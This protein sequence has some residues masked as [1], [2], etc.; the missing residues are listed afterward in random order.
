MIF[1]IFFVRF[2]KNKKK[3]RTET[4]NVYTT[5]G[6]VSVFQLDLAVSPV[7]VSLS[8]TQSRSKGLFDFLQIWQGRFLEVIKNI[9]HLKYVLYFYFIFKFLWPV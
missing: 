6:G 7:S 2:Q 4:K 8:F 3:Y 1:F 5:E 9:I